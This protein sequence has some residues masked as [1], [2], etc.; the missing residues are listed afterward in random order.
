MA[1]EISPAKTAIARR[2][3][4]RP[5]A[6]ALEDGVIA[7]GESVFD[8][9]QGRGTDVA[10]LA[11]EG[12]DVRG[13]DKFH[14]PDA[15]KQAADVV[16]MGFV[17]NVIADP[18]E[19]AAALKEAMSLAR[20]AAIVSVRTD[21]K[22]LDKLKGAVPY[23][24]GVLTTAH[25]FQHFYSDEEAANYLQEQTGLTPHRVDSGVY[26]LFKDKALERAYLDGHAGDIARRPT[27]PASPAPAAVGAKALRKAIA[28]APVGKT[29]PES[30]YVHHSAVPDL[31][32][33]LQAH[34]TAARAYAP[35]AATTLIKIDKDGGAV[36]FLDYEDFD[37]DPHSAL[38]QSTRVRLTD[39]TVQVRDYTHSGNR[40]ILHR[41]ESFVAA[42][43]PGREQF[44]RLSAAEDEAG[45]LSR[46]DIGFQ[47]QWGEALRE[48]GVRLDGHTLKPARK[49]KA[50]SWT[51]SLD[52]DKAVP[53]AATA[54]VAPD[55]QPRREP[56]APQRR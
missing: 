15:P 44:A 53:K 25:T 42:T 22:A 5:V 36:S 45:L 47:K 54:T 7:P 33:V 32:E 12:Y 38:K 30:F 43:Y 31:P 34:I 48:A 4:S 40:P 46:R 37:G 9:G 50:G 49:P 8:Y 11:Q 55:G 35:D 39:G 27:S 3:L 6:K 26:Y 24:D 28:E 16:N 1:P 17:L 56:R 21:V 29:L 51:A 19:R 13:W 14:A 20:R 10:L 18:A 23:S 2:A 52:A 41:K